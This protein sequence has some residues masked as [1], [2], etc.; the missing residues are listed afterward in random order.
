MRDVTKAS[1]EMNFL[2]M[3]SLSNSSALVAELRPSTILAWTYII[4]VND[5]PDFIF[6]SPKNNIGQYWPAFWLSLFPPFPHN[7]LR[8]NEPTLEKSMAGRNLAIL[9]LSFVEDLDIFR[10][11][12]EQVAL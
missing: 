2:C 11:T 6:L 12:I 7:T 10:R 4:L 3:S 9:H 5:H 1:L 8:K